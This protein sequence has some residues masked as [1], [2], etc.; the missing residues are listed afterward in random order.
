MVVLP[1]DVSLGRSFLSTSFRDRR[2]AL[3]EFIS[4]DPKER[5]GKNIS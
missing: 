4:M 1:G 5:D 2:L 3:V